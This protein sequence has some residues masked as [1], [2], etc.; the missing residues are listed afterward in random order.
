ML[1]YFIIFF[2]ASEKYLFINSLWITRFEFEKKCC[3]LYIYMAKDLCDIYDFI[4]H[5]LKFELA[6]SARIVLYILYLIIKL[7]FIKN[8]CSI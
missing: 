7:I 6:S 2:I 1:A 5:G 8:S 3:I 4:L